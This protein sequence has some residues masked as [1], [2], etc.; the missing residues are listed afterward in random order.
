MNKMKFYNWCAFYASTHNI[1]IRQFCE[2]AG[3]ANELVSRYKHGRVTPQRINCERLAKFL[4]ID[5]EQIEEWRPL[6]PVIPLKGNWHRVKPDEKFCPR[7]KEWL[8][9]E[10]FSFHYDK[11]KQKRQPSSYCTDHLREH[12]R[13]MAR[14]RKLRGQ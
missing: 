8:P 2:Q 11:K 13:Q 4:D 12:L 10:K 14:N 1:S 9:L 3:F 7:C 5:P 6:P